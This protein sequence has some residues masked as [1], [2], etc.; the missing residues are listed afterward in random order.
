MNL[1]ERNHRYIYIQEETREG[2]KK[3][4]KKTERQR[5]RVTERQKDRETERQKDRDTETH[6]YDTKTE[7]NSTTTETDRHIDLNLEIKQF[8]FLIFRS[9]GKWLQI[10]FEDFRNFGRKNSQ[11]NYFNRKFR[12]YF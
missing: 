10:V 1:E 4:Q 7:R 3:R 11:R 9:K 5:D 8:F 12:F 6:R 2:E